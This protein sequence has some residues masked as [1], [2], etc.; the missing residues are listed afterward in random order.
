MNNR[1]K[2]QRYAVSQGEKIPDQFEVKVEGNWFVLW[3]SQWVVCLFFQSYLHSRHSNIQ[4]T[5]ETVEG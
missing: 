2:Y 4:S 1:R 3:T 5:L